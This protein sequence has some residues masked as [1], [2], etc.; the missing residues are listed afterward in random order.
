MIEATKW[1]ANL[2]A[3]N[4]TVFP[5]QFILLV[6]AAGLTALFLAKPAAARSRWLQA[7]LAVSFAWIGV[8]FFLVLGDVLPARYGQAFLFLSLAALFGSAAATGAF[9]F[10]LPRQRWLR[11]ATYVGL[12]LAFLYPVV[13]WAVGRTYPRLLVPGAFPCPTTALAL[14]LMATA[15][16]AQQRWLYHGALALLLLWAIPFPIAIQIPQFGVYEDGIMLAMGLYAAVVWAVWRLK[17]VKP[18]R[19]RAAASS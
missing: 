8:V 13:G 1:W 11:I 19:A 2:A 16:R 18:S 17:G 3:Y 7:F 5:V 14:V 15:P 6:L 9:T 4:Q 12:A 10:S